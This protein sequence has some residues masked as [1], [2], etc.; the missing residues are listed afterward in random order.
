MS[1]FFPKLLVGFHFNIFARSFEKVIKVLEHDL[2]E[3]SSG[4]EV[5]N[6]TPINLLQTIDEYIVKDICEA[7]YFDK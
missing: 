5:E 3:K 1:Q 7:K 4:K 6:L 2:F